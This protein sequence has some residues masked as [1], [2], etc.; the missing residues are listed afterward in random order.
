[1]VLSDKDR[2]ILWGKSGNRCAYRYEGEICELELIKENDGINVVISFEAHIVGKTPTSARHRA[3]YPPEKMDSYENR[4]LLCGSHHKLIDDKNLEHIYTEDRVR[5]MKKEHET[6][7]NQN[8]YY[9]P[10]I[11]EK[12]QRLYDRFKDPFSPNLGNDLLNYL[13]ESYQY[14][15]NYLSLN[16][17]QE[18]SRYNFT[19][20]YANEEWS[21]CIFAVMSGFILILDDFKNKEKYDYK[22][23]NNSRHVLDNWLKYFRNKCRNRNVIIFDL[24]DF[25]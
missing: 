3:N 7:M 5:R 21:F 10:T 14:F 18:G 12:L 11:Q 25:K 1:M 22:E 23:P 16:F 8:G 4:I 2:K 6:I 24:E 19:G 17:Q 9:N 13:Q 15:L 20:I